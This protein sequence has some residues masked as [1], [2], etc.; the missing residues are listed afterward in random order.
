MSSASVSPRRVVVAGGGP[1][2][3]EGALRLHRL[4]SERVA[5]TLVAPG[6]D[7]VYRPLAVLEPFSSGHVPAFDLREVAAEHHWR[8]EQIGVEAVD[9][10]A[11]TVACDVDGL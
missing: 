1:A 4:A 7:F 11:R 2:A 6:T 5:V 9:V 10:A 3:L 8:F